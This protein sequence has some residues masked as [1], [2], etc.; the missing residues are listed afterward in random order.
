MDERVEKLNEI[1]SGDPKLLAAKRKILSSIEQL[2]EDEQG[3]TLLPASF[4]QAAKIQKEVVTIG[5]GN[6]IEIW[7]KEVY[8]KVNEGALDGRGARTRGLLSHASLLS[9]ARDARRSHPGAC[10][11]AERRVLRRNGGGRGHSFAILE[12]DPTVRLIGTDRDQEAIEAAAERLRP[13]E[14]RFQ[15]YKSDYRRY[16]E[17]LRRAGAD[18]LDGVLLDFGI[19]SHQID[20]EER[21]F[22]YRKA[23]AP[24]DMRMDRESGFTAEDVREQITRKKNSSASSGI[25]GRSASRARSRGNIVRAREECPHHDVRPACRDRWKRASP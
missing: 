4:R 9:Q 5:M 13:F 23:S 1:H 19:S 10:D 16:S 22:S 8:D 17:I 24:L 3:R 2:Q 25:T 7:A 14:G 20:D 12:S 21:G 18:K 11:P 15:L 6:Y